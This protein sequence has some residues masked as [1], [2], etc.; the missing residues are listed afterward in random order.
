MMV[1]SAQTQCAALVVEAIVVMVDLA[2][3][4][5]MVKEVVM[6]VT[7]NRVK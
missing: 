3:A 4:A 1:H 7:M 6:K 2:K 5:Q